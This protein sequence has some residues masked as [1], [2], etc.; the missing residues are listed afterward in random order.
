MKYII[1]ISLFLIS[2]S[3]SDLILQ[4]ANRTADNLAVEPNVVT[5]LY[6]MK[7]DTFK[8]SLN[9]YGEPYKLY[10]EMEESISNRLVYSVGNKE[11]MIVLP[12]NKDTAFPALH[13][14]KT[15]NQW[16][17]ENSYPEGKMTGARNY[18]VVDNNGTIV[19]CDFGTETVQPWPGGHLYI[20]KTI[21]DKLVWKQVSP[22]KSFYHSVTAADVNN[23]GLVDVIGSHMGSYN[24]WKGFAGG[25]HIYTQRPDGSFEENR[26]LM[27]VNE[28]NIWPGDHGTGAVYATNLFGDKRPEIIRATY[29]AINK[30]A[31]AVYKYSDSSHK[32]E[33]YN[34]PS[35][36]GVFEGNAGATSMRSVD[37]D[38]D[39]DNDLAIAYEGY[40][41]GVQIW[42]NNNNQM[43]PGQY[44]ALTDQE[45]NIR[46]F[47]IGDVDKNGFND[48]IL[49][50]F[51]Y[52]NLF[53]INPVPG[54]YRGDGIKLQNLIWKNSN[55]NYSF[56][57]KEINITNI[58]PCNIKGFYNN[59]KLKFNGFEMIGVKNDQGIK[60][61]EITL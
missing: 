57:T 7:I 24:D 52:G 23:D 22:K 56:S 37:Y 21:G 29:F 51:H 34:V 40:I 33:L 6:G 8:I 54:N 31:I 2:C 30:Y 25:I 4:P 32:Y 20:V 15:N 61:Y 19:Y 12:S 60:F 39:G 45:L 55:G 48:I 10:G 43:T 46:E 27:N 58:K 18:E 16:S 17:F 50:T 13:F 59:G 5:P 36:L 49:H 9:G 44:L 14:V 3:K 35:K 28:Q 53:R 41:N 11:H 26:T 47:E 38:N 42:I 1:I